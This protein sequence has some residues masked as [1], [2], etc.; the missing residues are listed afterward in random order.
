M[1]DVVSDEILTCVAPPASS[2]GNVSISI[3]LNG[4]QDFSENRLLFVYLPQFEVIAVHPT[5]GPSSG[6]TVIQLSSSSDHITSW[7]GSWSCV[8]LFDGSFLEGETRPIISVSK[9]SIVGG[10]WK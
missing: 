7:E 9:A 6:G 4:G 3:S 5:S 2:L 8:F 1:A 10:G